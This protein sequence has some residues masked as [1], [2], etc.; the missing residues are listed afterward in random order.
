MRNYIFIL[1]NADKRFDFIQ[2]DS[3]IGTLCDANG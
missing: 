3:S 2:F 1:T